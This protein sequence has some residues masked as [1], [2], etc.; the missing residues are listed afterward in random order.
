MSCSYVTDFLKKTHLKY[1]RCTVFLNFLS[2]YKK[3]ARILVKSVAF[4]FFFFCVKLEMFISETR[5]IR[6]TLRATNFTKINFLLLQAF[7]NV[8]SYRPS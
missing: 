6:F 2:A 5:F 8:K 1:N 3:L 4:F 7:D